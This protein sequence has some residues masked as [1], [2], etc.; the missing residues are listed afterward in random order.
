VRIL[1]VAWSHLPHLGGAELTTDSLASE[2]RRRDHRI[3]VLARQDPRRPPNPEVDRSL[4][5]P[6]LRSSHPETV[7]PGVLQSLRPDVMIVGGYHA[8]TVGWTE[9]ILTRAARLPTLLHLHDFASA[10]LAADA[11]LQ[12][13][14]VVAVSRFVAEQVE[15]SGVSVAC[16]PPA[17]ERGRYRVRSSRRVALFIN[18]VPQKGVEMALALARA[19]PDIPFAFTRCWYLAPEALSCLRSKARRLGN[20]EL[21]PAVKEPAQLY[22][23]AKLLLVPSAYPEAWARVAPEAQMSAIPV[24]AADTGGLPEAVGD[25]GILVD[26]RAGVEDWAKAL[27]GLW[28][29]DSGYERYVALAERA[30]RRGDVSPAA[31]GDRFES[32]LRDVVRR[33]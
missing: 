1:Y 23:D 17:V 2:L 5:Y 24:L 22:G 13:D 16:I 8:E 30:G 26:S 19:R 15:G 33:D 28:D 4:G 21:R 12:I 29:D 3:A 11:G 27:A 7:L 14:A 32:L 20:V 9:R 25:G 10:P 6:T 18:P 31:V